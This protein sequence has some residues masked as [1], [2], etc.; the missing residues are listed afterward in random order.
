M[1]YKIQPN[2]EVENCVKCGRRP[3]VGQSKHSWVVKCPNDECDNSISGSI[4]D[5][6]AWNRKN[7]PSIPIGQ[8]DNEAKKKSM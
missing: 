4:T 5:F 7:K 6:D 3:V 1:F 2:F 8:N